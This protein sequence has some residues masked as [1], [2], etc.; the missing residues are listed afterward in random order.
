VTVQPGRWWTKSYS[1]SGNQQASA[2]FSVRG[3]TVNAYFL[4]ESEFARFK[5]GAP[6]PSIR[7]ISSAQNAA[8]GLVGGTVYGGGYVLAFYNSS[9]GPVTI[10]YTGSIQPQGAK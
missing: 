5:A 6:W 10:V 4:S 9:P 1:F 7:L 3:G 2:R 8:S